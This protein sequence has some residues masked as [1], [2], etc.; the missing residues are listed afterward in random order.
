MPPLNGLTRLF[1]A[2]LKPWLPA[3]CVLCDG[4]G[5][6]GMD[7]C[8][9]CLDALPHNRRAC[10]QC[11]LPLAGAGTDAVRCGQCLNTPPRFDHAM[12][13][14][15][16]QDDAAQLI[17][18]L[19][20][21]DR[22][23]LSRLLGQLLLQ[24][25]IA[26]GAVAASASD[27]VVDALLPVP[28]HRQ[29]LRQ[30]GFNQSLELA[31]ILGRALKLPLLRGE[32]ERLRATGSQTGLDARARGRNIRGAFAVRKPLRYRHIAII[33]DV[34]TTGSTVNELARVLKKAG[35]ETVSVWSVAR[36]PRPK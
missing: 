35:V 14:F 33:D 2:T 10:C 30:R 28:L 20:F 16:Y 12:A 34:V 21:N 9:S 3:R 26:S 31:R 36:A 6:A 23:A 15:E 8:A 29:R 4:P 5:H 24:R 19:K 13:L 11:A 7:I 1:A 27:A 17:Q 22:L 18:Q 25:V 32:V